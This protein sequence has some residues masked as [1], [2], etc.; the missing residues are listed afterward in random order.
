M[1]TGACSSSSIALSA[2]SAV[3]ARVNV[4]SRTPPDSPDFARRFASAITTVLCLFRG[5]RG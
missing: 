3:A 4:A 1:V 2:S 5:L